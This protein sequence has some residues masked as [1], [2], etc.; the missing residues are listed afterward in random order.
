MRGGGGGGCCHVQVVVSI[1]THIITQE[2]HVALKSCGS[3]SIHITEFKRMIM[4]S[5]EG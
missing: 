4:V 2:I 1:Q 3:V 5:Y